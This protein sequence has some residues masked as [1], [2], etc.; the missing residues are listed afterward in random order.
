MVKVI[1]IEAS[2]NRIE[3]EGSVGDSVMQVAVAAG[4]E[5]ISADCGGACACGTCHCVMSEDWFARLPAPQSDEVDMLEFVIDPQPSSRL[6][7]QV[8]LSEAM[9]GIEIQ[10]PAS[11]I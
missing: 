5:A 6:S 8:T 7:C 11:Q 2:G 9:E 3:A 10:V 4:V 1:F